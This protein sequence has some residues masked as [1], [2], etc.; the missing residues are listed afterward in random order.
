MTDDELRKLLGNEQNLNNPLSEPEIPPVPEP[1]SVPEALPDPFAQSVPQP[2]ADSAE[3]APQADS[4]A[5]AA[6]QKPEKHLFLYTLMTLLVLGVLAF[7]VFCVIWDV[8]RGTASGGYR[9]GNVVRVELVQHRRNDPPDIEADE[10][11]K[12][13][14]EGIA[15]TVMPSI[16]EI[17]TY[18]DGTMTGAGSGIILSEDGYIAT[19]AHVVA[20]TTA[21]AVRVY[22][23]TTGDS[24][25][26]AV[27]VGH[28]SKTDLAVLKISA[29][30]LQ[31]AKLGNSD[32]VH[33][34]EVVCAL[35]NPAGLSSSITTG[36][37]SGVNRK[38]RAKSTNFEMDCIQ[39]DAAISPGNSGGALVDMYGQVI[40]ITSS[41]YGASMLFGGSYEGLGFAIS[42]NQALPIIQELMEKGY[43]SGRV[44]IGITIHPN[45]YVWEQA[46]NSGK[47][48]P[49][50]LNGRGVQV[51]SISDDSDL[52]NTPFKVNDWILTMNGQDV[53]D[54]D[55]IYAVT[56][57]LGGGDSVH[58]R[59]GHIEEDGTLTTFEIDFA[60]IE[61]Q[62]G[63]Y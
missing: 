36:I 46:K 54:Y 58:C 45:S 31:P 34:G 55:T 30:D 1:V 56:S 3:T 35:G 32:D 37:I 27:L 12:Y 60:L 26:S 41:K 51:I 24:Q 22:G 13:S 5:A 43:V 6:V 59:C 33:L 17:Y 4:A 16:V 23:D 25:Y 50:E 62:S 8:R 2:A 61:D 49:P 14:F 47:E 18:K 57:G 20:D 44:R 11:G 15:H 53:I 28:D 21:Y 10:N 39:T 42:I 63:E 38:V 40:G 52:L 48:L 19:N 29:A 9:A 7:A